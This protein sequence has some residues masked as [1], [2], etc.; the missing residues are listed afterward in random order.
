MTAIACLGWGSL[1]WDPRNLP[2]R[3]RWFADG[4]LLMA[5]FLRQSS[6]DRI[7]LVLHESAAPVR[8]LWSVMDCTDLAEARRALQARECC[9][10]G[11]IASWSQGQNGPSNIIDLPKWAEARGV[12][13]VVWTGLPPKM[14]DTVRCPTVDEVL[15]HLRRLSGAARENAERYIRRA[16]RQI[17]TAM[18]RRIEAELGWTPEST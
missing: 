2:I 18:R 9:S 3:R 10:E 1:I 11:H 6:D 17:D 4:P 8:S 7:T 5:E 13:A 15:G 16:P 12:G 14:G